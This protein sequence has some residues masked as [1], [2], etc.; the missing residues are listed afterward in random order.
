M[1]GTRMWHATKGIQ[2]AEILGEDYFDTA[3]RRFGLTPRHMSRN[4]CTALLLGPALLFGLRK[5]PNR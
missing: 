5:S 3:E 4:M 2:F 1:R